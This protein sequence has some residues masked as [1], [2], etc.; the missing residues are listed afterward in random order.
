[1]LDLIGDLALLGAY[2]QCEIIAV[3]S[4]HK[5]HC[6]AVRELRPAVPATRAAAA[7]HP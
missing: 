2:P 5:L 3:K 4:G 1:M 7:V 6:M